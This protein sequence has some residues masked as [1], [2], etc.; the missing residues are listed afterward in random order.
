LEELSAKEKAA[1]IL[2]LLSPTVASKVLSFLP[3]N[4]ATALN[5]N[6]KK[7]RSLPTDVFSSIVEEFNRI[8]LPPSSQKEEEDLDNED[9]RKPTSFVP[10]PLSRRLMQVLAGERTQLSAFVLKQVFPELINEVIPI[11]PAEKRVE[12]EK[13]IRFMHPNDIFPFLAQNIKE[14]LDKTSVF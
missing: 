14:Y 8:S 4:A 3:R 6:L 7:V 10:K 1:V 12:I 5:L 13:K 11:F 9:F 2:S